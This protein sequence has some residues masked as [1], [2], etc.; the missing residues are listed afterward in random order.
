MVPRGLL[1]SQ[2]LCPY[3]GLPWNPRPGGR[4]GYS[5]KVFSPMLARHSFLGS[6]IFTSIFPFFITFSH[7]TFTQLLLSV[8]QTFCT[9]SVLFRLCKV[10][11]RYVIWIQHL[12]RRHQTWLLPIQNKGNFGS[13][14][15]ALLVCLRSFMITICYAL[16]AET[17][18]VIRN[19]FVMN[20]ATGLLRNARFSLTITI[21]YAPSVNQNGVRLG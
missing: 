15:S 12:S 7:L 6:Y 1:G 17:R 8:V 19:L 13:V 10:P 11:L 20:A 14:L 18:Y 16:S 3:C 4:P 9:S 21:N 5:I 2:T